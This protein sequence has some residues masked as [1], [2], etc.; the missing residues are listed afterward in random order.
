[1]HKPWAFVRSEESVILVKTPYAIELAGMWCVVS[2]RNGRLQQQQNTPFP[3]NYMQVTW[4]WQGDERSRYYVELI[5]ALTFDGNRWRNL[6]RGGELR[7]MRRVICSLDL[8]P[9]D[10]CNE[11][12]TQFALVK[13]R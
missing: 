9:R 12:E 11:V 1:M 6:A 4:N 8:F 13:L 10:V 7:R 3:F 5:R 2:L